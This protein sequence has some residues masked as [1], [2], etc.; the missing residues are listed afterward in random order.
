MNSVNII[1]RMVADAEL[2]Y[3]PKGTAVGSLRIAVD[4]DR[5]NEAGER[6]SDFFTVSM[7]SG[8]AEFAANYLGKGRLIAI[9]GRL[10]T[11]S[12]TTQDGQK[13]TVVEIVATQIK[14]LDKPK[15]W[16]NEQQANDHQQQAPVML[17][18]YEYDPFDQE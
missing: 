13:R 10:Q 5:K 14:A 11:R 6:E 15:E 12:W 2:R 7:W 17:E 4:R 3:T 16:G 1:G 18:D 9:S 8:T